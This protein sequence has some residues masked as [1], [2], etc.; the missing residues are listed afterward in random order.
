MQEYYPLGYITHPPE[1]R[2]RR[3]SKRA[4]STSTTSKGASKTKKRR[5]STKL[6][7]IQLL[8]APRN[9]VKAIDFA[10]STTITNAG[11]VVS[12]LAS[13]TQG[14]NYFGNFIGR[15]LQPV[16]LDMRFHLVGPG[17]AT[18][19]AVTD[20]FDCV[21]ML[22]FQWMDDD[23][24]TIS[25]ILQTLNT[26]SPILMDNYNNINVLVDKLFP[27]W[28]TAFDAT[29]TTGATC[30]KNYS[31]RIYTKGKRMVPIEMGTAAGTKF[32]NGGVYLAFICGSTTAPHPTISYDLRL[33]F[34]DS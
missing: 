20:L 2:I 14:V 5:T 33:T 19:G 10:N 30:F 11:V 34:R 24:P 1:S 3:M 13:Y 6:N 23:V 15:T 7:Q 8:H 9:E 27:L 22:V 21:R 31:D 4:R 26:N 18:G 16:G 17:Q 28:V 32:Q 25:G 29:A 12:S